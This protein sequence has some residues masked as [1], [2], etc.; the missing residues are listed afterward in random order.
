MDNAHINIRSQLEKDIWD[1]AYDLAVRVQGWKPKSPLRYT[2]HKSVGLVTFWHDE[3]GSLSEQV[4]TENGKRT[5]FIE[6]PDILKFPFNPNDFI[7]GWFN[8]QNPDDFNLERWEKKIDFDGSL[9]NGF[10]IFTQ[11]W[12]H[13]LDS[14]YAIFAVKPI[15]AWYGK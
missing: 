8:N 13:V 9:G 1:S 10:R 15:Y 7:W 14:S 2:I 11:D 12:G 3:I 5:V 6:N 4:E